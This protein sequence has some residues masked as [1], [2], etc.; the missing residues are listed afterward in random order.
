MEAKFKSRGLRYKYDNIDNPA[1]SITR[2]IEKLSQNYQRYDRPFF[3]GACSACGTMTSMEVSLQRCAGC[4]LVSYC[5]KNCQ[6]AD[7]KMHKLLC[8][9]FPVEG[10]KSVIV[11]T[12]ESVGE[13]EDCDTQTFL[14]AL[15]QLQL[16][17]PD[18]A[19]GDHL[20]LQKKLAYSI[21]LEGSI[22][23]N[24]RVCSVCQDPRPENLFDCRCCAVSYCSDAH[25]K[26]DTDHWSYGCNHLYSCAMANLY[27]KNNH[28]LVIPDNLLKEVNIN[29]G[30][31]FEKVSKLPKYSSVKY[32]KTIVDLVNERIAF[33][34]TIHHALKNLK[35][36]E[37][38]KC[39]SDITNLTI[40]IVY[41]QPM[42]DPRMWEF[43]LHLLP[44]LMKLNLTFISPNMKLCNKF[45]S[46]IP[47]ERCS[48][49]KM[50]QK[51]IS[52]NIQSMHY[53]EYFSSD[54]YVQPDVVAVFD[55]DH[56]LMI[57]CNQ[58]PSEVSYPEFIRGEDNELQTDLF[59]ENAHSFTS[60]RNMTYS[61]DTIVILTG[62]DKEMIEECVKNFNEA[63]PV[64]VLIPVQFVA[65]LI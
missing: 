11:R 53:H 17:I 60:Q 43:F 65:L 62:Q 55:I 38:R 26:Q 44:N 10:G 61:M 12:A 5:N 34:L 25:R 48:D 33:P 7:W 50:K 41:N 32:L 39:I 45:N 31:N 21:N 27:F 8:K 13:Q 30:L 19:K 46:Y 4:Q 42:L 57:S 63:R 52:Y 14:D 64:D 59:T 1:E 2:M 51:V 18:F 35:F 23:L 49:C 29:D 6:K 15:W 36:G 58:S 22:M 40:H 24:A 54:D 9:E 37:Q 47:L 16:S 28:Q 3:S 20:Y 56:E